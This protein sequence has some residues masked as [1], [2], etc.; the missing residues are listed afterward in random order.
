MMFYTPNEN[1]T[2]LDKDN[3]AKTTFR[4]KN[5][6]VLTSSSRLFIK[7]DGNVRY[8][9][10]T[11]ISSVEL[12]A[13]R[14]WFVIGIGVSL[15]ACVLNLQQIDPPSWIASFS[16][17][18]FIWGY[19]EADSPIIAIGA[20]LIL[21]GFFWKTLSIKLKI[22]QQNDE[23]ALSGDKNTVAALFQIVNQYATQ[24]SSTKNKNLT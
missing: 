6:D 9:D 11:D 13:Q 15:A 3:I 1:K 19:G 21:V 7:N 18:R 16:L 2:L 24:A 20:I 12:S 22:S 14:K 8:I 5:K 17:G 23:I 4:L 10:Y